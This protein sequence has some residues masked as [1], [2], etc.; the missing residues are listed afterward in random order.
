MTSFIQKIAF[1]SFLIMGLNSCSKEV[2][3][4]IPGFDEQIV[5]DGSIETGTPAI[6]FLSN[7]KDIYAPTDI[8]SYLNGF[9]SGATVTVSNGTIT[10]TLTEICTDNL[11]AGFESIAA[12]FFGLP[13][14]QLVNLHLCAYVSIGLVGEVGKTYT[15][16]V[17]HNNKTY[18]SSTKIENPTAL[19]N[20]FWREQVNLPGYGFSWAKITDSPVMGDAYRWEVKNISDGSFS[21]PFQPFTDDRFYNGKTFEFSVENPMSFKDTTIENQYK[22]YYKLGDTIVVKFSK[23]G[24]KEYQFFE[25]KYNQ[26]FS[27]GNPFATPTNIPSNIEG[28]ALGIWAGFSPWYDTLICVP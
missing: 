26:I 3:I 10:D 5:I 9:I 16:K 4:D 6:I 12:A 25:K 7:S 1:L 8:N 20:L 14:E 13:I 19:D 15:L 22:G 11:P 27:G 17:I 28:G 24:K 23:L 2:K 21:K 18:T